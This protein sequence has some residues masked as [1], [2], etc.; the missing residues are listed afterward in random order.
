VDQS[1]SVVFFVQRIRN[2]SL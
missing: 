1:L 2:S